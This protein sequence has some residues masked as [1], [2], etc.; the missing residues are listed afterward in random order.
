MNQDNL[1]QPDDFPTRENDFLYQVMAW[2]Y[3]GAIIAVSIFIG[4]NQFTL[5]ALALLAAI[6]VLPSPLSGLSLIIGLTMIF[7]RFFT[8][9]PVIINQISY[10]I[11]PLDIIIIL[12]AVATA[13]FYRYRHYRPKI[14]W[15]LPEKSLAI[16]I[17]LGIIYL[18]RGLADINSEFYVSFSTF[19]NYAFYPLLYFLTILIITDEQ[20][21]KKIITIIINI[22]VILIVFIAFGIITGEGLWTEFTPLSTA[23]TR[24]L[25]YTHAF[26]LMLA[27][28]LTTGLIAFNRFPRRQPIAVI[29]TIW[30]IGIAGS[31]MRHLW[32]GLI[33]SILT[34]WLIIPKENKKKLSAY[35]LKNG[36][37]I[38]CLISLIVLIAYF[39]PDTAY[40]REF[41]GPI[42][43]F[44]E[45]LAS[46]GKASG[47]TS[48]SWRV[49]LWQTAEKI[50]L[51][52]PLWG[53]G[54]GRKIPLELTDWQTYE[55]IRN[56]HNSPL[57]ILIQM[58]VVGFAAFAVFTIACLSY[59][60]R[61]IRQSEELMPYYFGLIAAIVGTLFCSL[62]QPYLE[63]NLTAIFLWIFMGLLATARNIIPDQEKI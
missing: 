44:G 46:L 11:Y 23:G 49:V 4:I 14:A 12:T 3:L 35:L 62:F 24:I 20:K 21:L 42:K 60:W 27:A 29:L 40:Y 55:E 6:F 50:W 25:A 28:T 22:A 17:I 59:T 52:N 16:F 54:F 43:N 13:L 61:K 48:I 7:E 51:E 38:I 31:L 1:L 5:I 34:L 56:I 10:K 9:S 63:T 26:Y 19:K 15:Q 30:L 39:L 45:R 18:F 8:L 32:L 57:A 58:G 36:W 33:V 47:D 37:V 41:F 53:I 2:L